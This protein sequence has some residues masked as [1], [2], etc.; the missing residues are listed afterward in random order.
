MSTNGF[1]C[2]RPSLPPPLCHPR[3]VLGT[4]SRLFLSYVFSCRLAQAGP[5]ATR[6]Q[7]G[8][9]SGPGVFLWLHVVA[10]PPGGSI[11]PTFKPW[12]KQ[13]RLQPGISDLVPT[14]HRLNQRERGHH[15]WAPGAPVWGGR[16]SG[17]ETTEGHGPGPQPSAEL[18]LGQGGGGAGRVWPGG[19][20]LEG[21]RRS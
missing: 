2:Q 16:E 19:G 12:P 10:P 9:R 20:A 3:P 18:L 21:D 8:V 14:G 11:S 17:L 6:V 7:V 1:S 4:S 13:L 5:V 15:P